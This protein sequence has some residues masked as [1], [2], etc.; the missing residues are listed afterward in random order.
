MCLT[1]THTTVREKTGLLSPRL[2]PEDAVVNMC[3]ELMVCFG[4]H[5]GWD[6]VSSYK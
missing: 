1:H 5:T 2:R 6:I 4:E 3:Y